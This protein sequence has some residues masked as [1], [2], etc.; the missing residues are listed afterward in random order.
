MY[1]GVYICMY[2]HIYVQYVL[3]CSCINPLTQ[4]A[5]VHLDHKSKS[6]AGS[7]YHSKPPE[8]RDGW[9][10]GWTDGQTDEQMDG[11][12]DGWTGG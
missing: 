9:M 2:I 1:V 4:P 5:A 11:W 12:M 8:H 3:P 10:D 7:T 6:G